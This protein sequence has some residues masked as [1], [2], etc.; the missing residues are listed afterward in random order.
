MYYF[1]NFMEKELSR[2]GR[3]GGK[4]LISD[5][6]DS[7]VQLAECYEIED[8]GVKHINFITT[9]E[10]SRGNR[11]DFL[12]KFSCDRVGSTEKELM[13]TDENPIILVATKKFKLYSGIPS[14]VK[15]L[16]VKGGVLIAL[17]KGFISVE[18]KDGQMLPL[19]RNCDATLSGTSYTYTAEDVRKL[20]IIKDKES[21]I[22]YSDFVVN[23]CIISHTVAK[24][25]SSLKSV[26][27]NKDNF[28]ILNKE[29]FEEAKE[30]KLA[31]L[32]AI[33][34]E[35]KRRAEEVAR[36]NSEYK[37]RMLEEENEASK[38]S[39]KSQSKKATNRKSNK[40]NSSE[41]V[42]GSMGA[43]FFLNCLSQ[44]N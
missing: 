11:L 6:L 5:T 28:V 24:D 22:L 38:K 4:V 23:D 21:D 18:S 13:S 29:V 2:Y 9:N 36:F 15:Y 8:S 30:R 41:S 27:F 17:I 33:E 7:V 26:K 16:P 12:G 19:S 3:K 40:E 44:M 20:N 25:G 1:C 35:K 34:E 43:Q 14:Y 32:K 31:E 10:K 42:T 37:K 39:A